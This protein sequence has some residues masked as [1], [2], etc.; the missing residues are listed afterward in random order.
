ME[1]T[2]QGAFRTI[3][4]KDGVRGFWAGEREGNNCIYFLIIFMFFVAINIPLLLRYK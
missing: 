2:V 1:T 4:K 3:L